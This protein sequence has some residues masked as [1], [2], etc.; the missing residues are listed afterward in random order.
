MIYNQH[1][2][3]GRDLIGIG[4]D[5]KTAFS[6][7]PDGIGEVM[8]SGAVAIFRIDG[9]TILKPMDSG[10]YLI[11][12]LKCDQLTKGWKFDI[13]N[14]QI[15]FI[16][17]SAKQ[18]D[19]ARSWQLPA[20][21]F[22][23]TGSENISEHMG[24]NFPN[25]IMNNNTSFIAV[26]SH[27]GY[28]TQLVPI[29][30][31]LSQVNL[32]FEIV[33][34]T[35]SNKNS[36]EVAQVIS[37][38]TSFVFA[39]DSLSVLALL[40]DSTSLSGQSFNQKVITQKTPAFFFGKTSKLMGASYTDNLYTDVY[41]SY[42]GKMTNNAGLNLFGDALF[43]TPVFADGDYYENKVSSVLWGMMRNRKRLGIYLHGD[44]MI[45]TDAVQNY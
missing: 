38:A 7:S 6:I 22:W 33:Y 36:S 5:D 13:K 44:A 40:K 20:A 30:D 31:Y 39:G 9:E 2:S 28:S 34:L 12:G 43:E 29:I 18:V 21:N 42:R 17:P 11:G 1:F 37:N 23:L 25:F 32:I 14:N 35:N 41:A 45:V 26:I 16:P 8:G 4:V 10:N 19:I 3:A 27:P 24:N 15:V